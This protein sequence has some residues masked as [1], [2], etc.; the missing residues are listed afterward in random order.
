MHT[1]KNVLFRVS[2]ATRLP[3]TLKRFCGL[4]GAPCLPKCTHMAASRLT[5]LCP[6]PPPVQLLE[7]LSIRASNG[8]S[9]LM[10]VIKSPVTQYFP[11]GARRVGLSHSA[12]SVHRMPGFVAQLP[13]EAPVVFVVGSMAHGRVDVTYT[14]EYISISQFP[15]SAAVCLG[16]ICNALETKLDIV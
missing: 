8:P 12:A 9:K 15:L 7:K 3:R 10:R 4:M 11:P 16:R 5:P 13:A 1:Q 6:S 2:P 14:D